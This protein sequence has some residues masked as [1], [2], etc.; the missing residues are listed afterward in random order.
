MPMKVSRFHCSSL[1]MASD[2]RSYTNTLK[3]D[4]YV[5]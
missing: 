1:I 5:F 2:L 3:E 4:N